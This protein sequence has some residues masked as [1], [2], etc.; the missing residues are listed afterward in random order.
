MENYNEENKNKRDMLKVMSYQV[1]TAKEQ[2]DVI[3]QLIEQM[4]YSLNEIENLHA[5]T[6]QNTQITLEARKD[7]MKVGEFMVEFYNEYREHDCLTTAQCKELKEALHYQVTSITR[8]LAP[9]LDESRK[10]GS[11]YL[12]IWINVNKA[13]WS[14]FKHRVN[15]VNIP[16]DRTPKIKFSQSIEFINSITIADYLA[17]KDQR[18]GDIRSFDFIETLQDDKATINKIIGL[19]DNDDSNDNP[20]EGTPDRLH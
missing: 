8:I 13:L 2:A 15:G 16:Y 18:W 4:E 9:R 20:S 17:Y 11:E 19:V 7:I 10:R 5:E 1:K 6:R 12:K 3:S 14:I